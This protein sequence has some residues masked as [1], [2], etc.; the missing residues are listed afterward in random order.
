MAMANSAIGTSL[1]AARERRGLSREALAYHSGISWS[2]ISQIETG[3]RTDVRLSSLS[4]LATALGVPID[5]LAGS[6]AAP[7]PML[8]HRVL[9]YASDDEFLAAVGPYLREG[10]ERSDALLV[11]TG[12]TNLQL[13]RDHLGNDA[14]KVELTDATGWYSSPVEALF[15]YRRFLEDHLDAGSKWVRIV[16]EPVWAG[17]SAAE[18]REWT[19]YESI[20]NLSFAAAP[21][22]IVCPY[23]A[24]S[25]P[26]Q[27]VLD[28]GC[29]H[30]RY[31]QAEGHTESPAYR[32]PE[33]FQLQHG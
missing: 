13:V 12:P 8:E 29:T 26:E 16:G 20:L 2:A 28:A 10:L 1:R 5:H 18:I 3:R 23:D 33:D 4:A 27:V 21:A 15:R 19:R 24:R 30:P 17:R 11:V 32:Q 25:V 6:T 14:A 7:P 22:T 9:I 31:E